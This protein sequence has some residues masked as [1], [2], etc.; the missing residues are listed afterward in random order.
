LQNI[1]K[2]NCSRISFANTELTF[3]K[4]KR[5]AAELSNT[6]LSLQNEEKKIR[7]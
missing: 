5:A 1:E 4:E 7:S 6:E 2:E 3:Q